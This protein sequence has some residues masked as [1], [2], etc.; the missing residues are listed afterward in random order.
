VVPTLIASAF[1]LP[2]H[3]LPPEEP[4]PRAATAPAVPDKTR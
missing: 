1:F 4:E 3:L 2:H